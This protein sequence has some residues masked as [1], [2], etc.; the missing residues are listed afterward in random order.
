MQQEPYNMAM[1]RKAARSFW[2]LAMETIDEFSKD[3]GDLVA[4]AL[5]FYAL[6]SIAPLI[7]VAVAIAGIILGQG[8]ARHEVQE[9]LQGAMGANMAH[10]VDDWVQE[11]SKSGG[12]AS[13]I[14]AGLTLAAASKFTAQLRSALNQVWNIDVKLADTF[15]SSIKGYFARELFAFASI[16]AAGPLL[17]AI[18]ASRAIIAGFGKAVLSRFAFTGV[19]TQLLQIAFSVVLVALLSAV[20]FRVI[21]DT[22]VRWRAACWGAVLTSLLFNV[23]NLLVGFYLGKAAVGAAYGAAGSLVVVLLWL[24]FS[25]YMF[26]LGA[27]FTQVYSSHFRD[28]PHETHTEQSSVGSGI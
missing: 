14:G 7:I 24:Y 28:K 23:G 12:I 9:L 26:L 18:V 8:N 1:V 5:A 20:V 16:L 19:A 10:V 2:A 22:K 13:V 11:A 27:E 15:K 3:R 4:A 21:P 6:L 17:L 25:A